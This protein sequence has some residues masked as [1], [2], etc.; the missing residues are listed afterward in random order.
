[1]IASGIHA[2]IAG[3]LLAM[4]IPARTRIDEDSFV[5]E[6][7]QA[8]SH[9]EVA[10]EP[11]ASPLK[12]PEHQGAVQQLERLAEQ[13]QPPLL[14]L[15]HGLH[16][17]VAFGVMPL[18]ALANAGVSL[19]LSQL[20]SDTGTTVA[21]GVALGLLVGKPLGITLFAWIAVRLGLASL[22]ERVAWRMIAGAG[23][24]G[25]IGFTM[26]LFIAELAFSGTP[27][28]L[29]AAKLGILGASLLAG[30]AGWAVLRRT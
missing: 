8:I 22:P 23:L 16:G 28:L 6:A 25:G 7:R 18:F 27:E 20:T 12:D 26:A 9:F 1:V 24:L 10:H 21:Q 14:R 11:G 5:K 2:T 13:L 19:R 29:V 3:V 30:L 17:V 15:E 4:T